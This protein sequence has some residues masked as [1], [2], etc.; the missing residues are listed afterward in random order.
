MPNVKDVLLP[1]DVLHLHPVWRWAF[2]ALTYLL[3]FLPVFPILFTHVFAVQFNVLVHAVFFYRLCLV[4]LAETAWTWRRRY[5]KND[6]YND[7]DDG[8][9]LEQ[10]ILLGDNLDFLGLVNYD[11]PHA[12]FHLLI[13]TVNDCHLISLPSFLVVVPIVMIVTYSLHAEVEII[14]PSGHLIIINSNG[15]SPGE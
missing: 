15:W 9:D 4:I 1:L 2:Q 8:Y 11:L 7:E 6:N 5:P 12:S 13:P 14:V 10:G 3:A